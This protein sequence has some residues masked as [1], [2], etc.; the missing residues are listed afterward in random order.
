MLNF[1]LW[2]YQLSAAFLHYKIKKKRKWAF[3]FHYNLFD[4]KL[5]PVW[6]EIDVKI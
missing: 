4:R 5:S 2:K 6:G 1:T 3:L